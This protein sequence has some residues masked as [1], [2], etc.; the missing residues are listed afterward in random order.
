[1]KRFL[2]GAVIVYVI[3][4]REG[5]NNAS[6]MRVVGERQLR[7]LVVRKRGTDLVSLSSLTSGSVLTS[8]ESCDYRSTMA[9]HLV[10]MF[11]LNQIVFL[12]GALPNGCGELF[13]EMICNMH[14]WLCAQP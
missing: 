10:L 13:I 3:G 14:G 1:M 2:A 11:I 4:A 6:R 5:T 7:V 9:E 12:P 8:C